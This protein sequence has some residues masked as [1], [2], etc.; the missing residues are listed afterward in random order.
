MFSKGKYLALLLRHQPEKGNLTLDKQGY[1]NTLDVL[2]AL[3]LDFSDLVELVYLD[4][5]GRYEFNDDKSKIRARQ[6]HSLKL[7]V[8][9][10][11]KKYIPRSVVYHGTGLQ[12]VDQILKSGLKSMNRQ[13]VH[14]SK[15]IET[16]TKVGTRKGTPII[17]KIDA[18]KAYYEGGINFYMSENGVIL[19]KEIPAIYITKL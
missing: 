17:L 9:I 15:D 1:A 19:A 5:K 4:D 11:F 14:L 16:A 12:N 8:D 3:N 7:K 18:P 10:D 13:Y 2:N 6:G